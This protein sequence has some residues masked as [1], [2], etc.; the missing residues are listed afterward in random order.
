MLERL[1]RWVIARNT[2]KRERH[3]I[4]LSM[5]L[6]TLPLS[7]GDLWPK[8]EAALDLVAQHTPAWL[9]RMRAMSNEIHVRRIPGN[10][11]R[12]EQNRLTI[13]DPYL[14]AN[15]PPAQI[16]ASIVHEGRR[17]SKVRRPSWIA[18]PGRSRWRMRKSASWSI[19][20]K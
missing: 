4:P 7:S 10:R 12:L 8:L 16:A 20:R 1:Q 17:A 9:P 6:G 2:E 11:A 3:G 13:L 19:G 18:R 14:L 15:F 5:Y